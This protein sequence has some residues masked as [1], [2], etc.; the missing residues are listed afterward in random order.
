MGRKERHL[1]QNVGKR[2]N[3]STAAER[4]ITNN[5]NNNSIIDL[6][7]F[8]PRNTGADIAGFFQPGFQ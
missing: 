7:L 6:F 3:P 1:E 5:T 2:S 4:N 8:M